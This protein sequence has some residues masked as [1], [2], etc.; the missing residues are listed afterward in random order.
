MY[1]L[2][3]V[4]DIALRVED[5][6][7]PSTVVVPSA[8]AADG[9]MVGGQYLVLSMPTRC[10]GREC[11]R[12]IVRNIYIYIERVSEQRECERYIYI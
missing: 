6:H 11:V 12:D 9:R 8:A 4:R 7:A 1:N 10:L 3:L 2:L 5:L